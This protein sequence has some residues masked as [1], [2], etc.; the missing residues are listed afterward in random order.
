[1]TLQNFQLNYGQPDSDFVVVHAQEDRQPVLAV[2]PIIHLEEYFKRGHLS[3]HQDYLVV[4]GNLEAF[5]RIIINKYEYEEFTQH[6]RYG[7]TFPRLDITLADI[8][9]SG[10]T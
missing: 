3:G 9:T 1:M 2:I 7:F 8:G 6:Y 4:D 5:S 10:E